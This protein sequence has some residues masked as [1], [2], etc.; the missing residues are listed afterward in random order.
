MIFART[1]GRLWRVLT[2]PI[3]RFNVWSYFHG[4]YK[5]MPDEEFLRFKFKSSLGYAL[6][7][8]N[9]QTLCEKLQWLKLYDRR[10]EYTSMVDK[11]AVKKIVA[12]KIGSEHVIPLIRV[13]DTF[14]DINFDELPEQFVLKCTHDSG[15][16]AICRDK[17]TFDREAAKRK[18]T[19]SLGNN[20]FWIAREWPYK[21]V[22]PRIIVEEFVD[23]LGKDNSIEYK[24]TCYNGRVKF[25]TICRGPAHDLWSKRT[26]EHYD[27][28]FNRLNFWVNYRNPREPE[29][30]PEQMHE[31]IALSDKLAEGIPQVRVDWYIADGKIY[32]GEMTFFT[33]EGIMRFNPPEWDKILGSWLELPTEKRM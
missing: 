1:A 19:R 23:A 12:D 32:F 3:S 24:L 5:Q 15:G 17:S 6:N 27:R 20:Y 7:L 11:L 29:K 31:L 13:Y 26:N 8:D 30:I 33:W 14:D 28:D 4:F 25:F 2:D 21:N 9:P 10:P 18:L 16:L 22:Q